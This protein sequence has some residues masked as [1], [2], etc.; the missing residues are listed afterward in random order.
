MITNN[1]SPVPHSKNGKGNSIV[2]RE[3]P[4]VKTRGDLMFSKR[5]ISKWFSII[6]TLLIGAAALAPDAFGIPLDLRPWVFLTSIFWL[7][8]FCSGFFSP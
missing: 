7:L 5:R 4:R 2:L 8:A 6:S 3:M 1:A